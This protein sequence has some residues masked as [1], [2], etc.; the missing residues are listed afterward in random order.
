MLSEILRKKIPTQGTHHHQQQPRY[1]PE[2]Q[3]STDYGGGGM[4]QHY[5]VR[6]STQ[7]TNLQ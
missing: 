4:Y 5:D 7:S 6:A 1:A 3:K 2:H